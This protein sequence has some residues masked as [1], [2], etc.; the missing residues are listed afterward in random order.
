MPGPVNDCHLFQTEV[1]DHQASLE[2]NV[3]SSRP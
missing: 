1:R 2:V 3:V